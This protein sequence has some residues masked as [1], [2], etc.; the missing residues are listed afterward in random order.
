LADIS[1]STAIQLSDIDKLGER[2]RS[3]KPILLAEDSLMLEKVIVD[4]LTKAQYT[5]LT[6][7]ANGKEA[8]DILQS[9]KESE[10]PLE[11]LC[12][13]I[14][15]DIEM[16]QMDGHR[17]IKLIRSDPALAHIPIIIF[18]SLISPEMRVKGKELGATAQISKPEINDLV[19]VIDE[20]IL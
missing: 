4:C 18:S 13:M 9:Y 14:I 19:R 3:T 7:T 20:H 15:T 8:W 16:P 11:S 1:P 17:L 5:N 12:S 10:E 6:M 2:P